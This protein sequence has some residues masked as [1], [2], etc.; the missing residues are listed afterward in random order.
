MKPL[1]CSNLYS[2]NEAIFL[3][4]FFVLTRNGLH[5]S[6]YVT[7]LVFVD[8]AA[9]NIFLLFSGG[10][11]S[12]LLTNLELAAATASWPVRPKMNQQRTLATN[13]TSTARGDNP[14][15]HVPWQVR[16]IVQPY[17]SPGRR[18]ARQARAWC[19]LVRW[20][21]HHLLVSVDIL[22]LSSAWERNMSYT[23]LTHKIDP[24]TNA[25]RLL[26][27]HHPGLSTSSR[28]LDM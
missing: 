6:L 7:S 24:Q 20:T 5:W 26:Q 12:C 9:T 4:L 25:G 17:P 21:S 2:H 11:T 23:R 14:P 10:D 22:I 8:I 16:G 19:S 1:L 3:L 13:G 18:L 15:R 28:W 27:T